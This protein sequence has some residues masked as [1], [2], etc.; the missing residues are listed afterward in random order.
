MKLSSG[1]LLRSLALVGPVALAA[2]GALAQ[3]AGGFEMT[4]NVIG[5][6]GAMLTHESGLELSGTIGQSVVGSAMNGTT[7]LGS[8]FWDACAAAPCPADFNTDGVVNSQDFFDFLNQFFAL[9]TTSDFNR[10]GVINSQDFFDFLN[11][12]FAGCP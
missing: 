7:V 1:S 12:F 5:A 4:C 2:T 10:D 9:S 6:G 8:G 3:S 11:A